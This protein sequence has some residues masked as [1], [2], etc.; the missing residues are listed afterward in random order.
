MEK[1]Q[2]SELNETGRPIADSLSTI[3]RP[4]KTGSTIFGVDEEIR[5]HFFRTQKDILSY[6]T[7]KST[8][9]N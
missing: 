8:K 9:T 1:T 2:L 7:I 4:E 5:Q 3:D 6:A